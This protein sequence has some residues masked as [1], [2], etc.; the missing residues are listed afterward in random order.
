MRVSRKDEN[1]HNATVQVFVKPITGNEDI[2]HMLMSTMVE[3]CL[4][5][6]I[7]VKMHPLT[8]IQIVIQLLDVDGSILS[9]A[10]NGAMMGLIDAGIQCNKL[11]AAVTVTQLDSEMI[12]DPSKDDEK[13]A[14]VVV[15]LAFNAN[16][17]QIILSNTNGLLSKSDYH[18]IINTAQKAALKV[19]KFMRKFFESTMR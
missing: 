10:I 14:S 17:Q 4:S 13:R 2:E 19:E 12:V 6:V 18:N 3:D 7:L 16:D 9:C 15:N 1:I 11:L 5:S 8:R